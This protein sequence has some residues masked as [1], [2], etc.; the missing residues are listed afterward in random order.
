MYSKITI[1]LS[2]CLALGTS[3][4]QTYE[5]IGVLQPQTPDDGS[6]GSYDKLVS[7]TINL[8]PDIA[9]VFERV[10][11]D[12]KPNDPLR[13]QEI[14]M[15]FMPITRKV[16]RATEEVDGRSFSEDEWHRFNAA[17]AVMPSVLTFMNNLREMDFFGVNQDDS[18]GVFV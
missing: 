13:V 10:S 18:N 7:A 6:L 12:H 11:R 15:D 1:L 3:A 4:P 9:D 8:L 5:A 17:E 16:M 2:F 14:F